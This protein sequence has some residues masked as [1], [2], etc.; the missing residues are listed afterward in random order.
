MGQVLVQVGQPLPGQLPG[1]RAG[2]QH[3]GEHGGE[4]GAARAEGCR[5]RIG[6]PPPQRGQFCGVRRRPQY[7]GR[8]GVGLPAPGL[9]DRLEPWLA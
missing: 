8:S 6:Q 5:Q 2:V 3:D 1:A 7:D 4:P 9:G